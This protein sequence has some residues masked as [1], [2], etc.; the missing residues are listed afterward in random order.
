MYRKIYNEMLEWKRNSKGKTSLLI[1]GARRVGKSYIA[2]KF[3]KEEYKSYII[4]DFSYL[5]DGVI[6]NYNNINDLDLF[7]TTIMALYNTKL[8]RRESLIIFDEIQLYP[9]ARQFLKHLIADG[10]YDYIETGSLLSI[11]ENVKNILIPSEEHAI[12]MYPMDFEEFLIASNEQI[13]LKL[14]KDSFNSLQ[15]LGEILHKKAM[16]LFRQ[17]MLV[18]GMPQVVKMYIDTKDFEKVDILKR[19]ILHLYKNDIGKFAGKNKKNIELLFNSIPSNLSKHEKKVKYSILGKN[20]REKNTNQLFF[21]L[22]DSKIANIAKNSTEPNVGLRLNLDNS[23]YKCYLSDTGL[24][25]SHT[26]TD[27]SFFNNSFYK[28]LLL[29]NLGVNE[30]M[31]VENV[32]AQNLVANG[33]PLFFYLNKIQKS[34][35]RNSEID[36]LININAAITPIEVKSSKN[37]NHRSLDKLMLKYPT[38]SRAYILSPSDILISEKIV[39]LPLYM[40]FLL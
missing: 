36:F 10:R 31:F 38:I 16:M 37:K 23:S 2:N 12:Q 40:A 13:F 17:Y 30:G 19:E 6:Q 20:A 1:E 4:I 9:F 7:F 27:V 8:F 18:G 25:L 21:W 5:K 28:A 26:F 34:D 39:F 3:G 22:E 24:L 15:P 33:H 32:V 11:Q 29:D 35:K 14:I